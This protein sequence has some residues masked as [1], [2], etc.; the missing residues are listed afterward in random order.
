MTRS[1]AKYL[2]RNRRMP[3]TEAL[4]ILDAKG[5]S[6]VNLTR[7]LLRANF[8]KVEAATELSNAGL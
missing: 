6:S 2:I 4:Q 8:T 5:N 3:L 7:R 1:E